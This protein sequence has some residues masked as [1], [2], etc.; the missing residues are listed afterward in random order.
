MIPNMW[1]KLHLWVRTHTHTN[2]HIHTL[3]PC[4]VC[5]VHQMWPPR[6][7]TRTSPVQLHAP[8]A[9]QIYPS[10]ATHSLHTVS[11]SPYSSQTDTNGGKWLTLINDV[12]LCVS[13]LDNFFSWRYRTR[14]GEINA[15]K[16]QLLLLFL[17]K[18]GDC[19]CRWHFFFFF[20]KSFYPECPER[21]NSVRT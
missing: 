15:Q 18:N 5:E 12:Q 9:R 14:R 8:S 6:A 3:V 20:F 13:P 19:G 16:I 1:I 4:D 17:T 11:G 2:T 21:R 10:T 7:L